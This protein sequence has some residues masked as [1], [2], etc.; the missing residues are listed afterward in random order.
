MSR[1][2]V[3]AIGSAMIVGGVATA[4]VATPREV[5][6]GWFAY[7]PLSDATFTPDG[8]IVLTGGA[9]GALVVAAIGVAVLAFWAGYTVRGSRPRTHD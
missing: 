3:P 9:L 8:L 2:F 6:F 4:V 5:S 7:A 1:W